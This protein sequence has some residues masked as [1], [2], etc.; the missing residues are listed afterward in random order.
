MRTTL[1]LPD[2]LM[3]ELKARAALEGVKLKDYFANIAQA[4]LQR[5]IAN[6]GQPARSPL[7]VFKRSGAKAMPIM[8]NAQLHAIL[9]AKDNV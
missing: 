2:S 7:P 8:S 3:R 9:D 5:P 1:D 6:A 4:A